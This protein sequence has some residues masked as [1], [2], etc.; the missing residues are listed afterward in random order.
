MVNQRHN[1]R[2]FPLEFACIFMHPWIEYHSVSKSFWKRKWCY[3][4][5]CFFS[6]QQCTLESLHMLHSYIYL[7]L[8]PRI[9]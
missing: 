5:A 4:V 8:F 1:S 7:I 3:S 6:I 9:S 2:P